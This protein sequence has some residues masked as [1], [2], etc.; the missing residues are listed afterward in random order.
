MLLIRSVLLLSFFSFLLSRC[1]KNEQINANGNRLRKVII[2]GDSVAYT[3]YNYNKKNRLTSIIRKVEHLGSRPNIFIYYDIQGRMTKCLFFNYAI[4]YFEYDNNDRIIKN[5]GVSLQAS[6][7]T[8]ES[9][10]TYDLRGRLI[11][12]SSYSK[13]SPNYS[14]YTKF[15]YDNDDNVIRSEIF[16]NDNGNIQKVRSAQFEYENKASPYISIGEI[17]YFI[18]KNVFFLSKKNPVQEKHDDRDDLYNGA[19]TIGYNF[20]YTPAGLPKKASYKFTPPG[21]ANV[22]NIE[23]LYDQG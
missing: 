10:Y 18:E 6:H 5:V 23:F 7:D 17:G 3:N 2:T 21:Y 11:V 14:A 13:N 19:V 20:E 12:D 15:S 9:I 1:S 16:I 22:Y 4:Y 8:A